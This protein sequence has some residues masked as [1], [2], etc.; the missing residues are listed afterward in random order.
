MMFVEVFVDNLY[1]IKEV[2]FYCQFAKSDFYCE[3][4]LN[5]SF[6]PLLNKSE[7]ISPLICECD[8]L[9]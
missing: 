8:D 3:W 7:G 1:Y 2:P 9:H 4:V 5:L 6:F